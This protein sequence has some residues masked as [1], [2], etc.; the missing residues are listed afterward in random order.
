MNTRPQ[1]PS[2][3]EGRNRL[4]T[5]GLE[6]SS[7]PLLP[8]TDLPRDPRGK[9]AGMRSSRQLSVLSLFLHLTLVAIHIALLV[10]WFRKW[11]HRLVF[12]IENENFV[13][14]L[15]KG[16]S[17]TFVT[18]YSALL[19]FVTQTLSF[20][21]DFRR[22]QML[23]AT[24]DNIIAWT[25]LG[26]AVLRLWQQRAIPASIFGVLSALIYLACLLLLHT[27][28]P[29]MLAPKSFI[30][31][32]SLA[33]STQS[34]PAFN[35]SGYD[36]ADGN[37]RQN[38]MRSAQQYAGGSLSFFPFLTPENTLGLY[39]ATLYDVLDSNMGAGSV[40]VNATSFNIS[41]GYIPDMNVT[42]GTGLGPYL[43]LGGTEYFLAL[44]D[45]GVIAPLY[46]SVN[47][48]TND[49]TVPIPFPSPSIFYTSIPVLD[50]NH[51][52]SPWV[53]LTDS[54]GAQAI[55]L[56]RCSL[57]LV[58]QTAV[59]DSQSHKLTFLETTIN[60]T[61]STWLPFSGPSDNL[62]SIAFENAQGFLNI[63]ES[64]YT[65][66]PE[67][68][69]P[70][71]VS[72][73]STF[74]GLSVADM[75]LIQ[76][77][78]LFPFNTTSRNYVYLHE[79]EKELA[80]I[81]ASMF[82]TLGHVPPLSG[83]SSL[84]S[85]ATPPPVLNVALLGGQATAE[86]LIVQDRLDLNIISI[87][88]G[89]LASIIL[90]Y[91]SARFLC[92][93]K[94]QAGCTA[95]EVDGVDIL[96]TIWLY[97][98]HSELVVSLKQVEY[99]TDLNLRK[100]GMVPIQ[101]IPTTLA[102]RKD[103]EELGAKSE[104]TDKPT[105]RH[106]E[107]VSEEVP[108]RSTWN[109]DRNLSLI[110]VILHS[111]LLVI[112]LVLV[113][114]S[115]MEIEHRVIFSLDNQPFL[116]WLIT[117]IAT[118]FIT[119]YSAALIF[120]TQTLSLK[121]FLR[122]TQMLA[123]T[124]DTIAAWRGI[125]SA[126]VS[127]LNQRPFTDSIFGVGSVFL[128]L[129]SILVLHNT[130]PV[131]LSVQTFDS[132]SSLPV[133]TQSLPNFTFSNY[134]PSSLDARLNVLHSP[135]L[136]AQG[137]LFFLPFLNSSAPTLG[138]HAGSLYDVLEYNAGTGN[139]TVEATGMNMNCG[140]LADPVVNSSVG[141]INILGTDYGLGYTELGIISTL[142]QHI[143]FQENV[144]VPPFL[145]SALFYSTVPIFD[146]NGDVGP[147]VNITGI[148]DGVGVSNIQIFRCSL[149]P[150]KQ[151]AIIDAQS[152]VL[153][154]DVINK[155]SSAWK[156]FQGTSENSTDADSSPYNTLEDY[157]ESWY[158]AMPFSNIPR[159]Y[160]A[161]LDITVSEMFLI[162]ELNLALFNSS[163]FT[164]ITLHQ[165]ESALSELVASM[166]W[167]MGHIPPLPG[168]VPTSS[169]GIGPPP[170]KVSLIQGTA[171][172]TQSVFKARLDSSTSEIIVGGVASAILLLLSLQF[173][174]LR[175][176]T[177]REDD[178][179]TGMG[180]LHT[181]WLYRNHPQLETTLEQVIHPTDVNLRKAGMVQTRLAG[182]ASR[183]QDIRGG[184]EGS[185]TYHGLR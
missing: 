47:T 150:I 145:G 79:V 174:V 42:L 104:D 157:W 173:V 56:F 127:V 60:K 169:D 43:S 3:S 130:S 154:I 85:T 40:S 131:L 112:H 148:T 80:N 48:D 36:L 76:R 100:A 95:A 71:S 167:T 33:V 5:F 97:R 4:S 94:P 50:S 180:M 118:I 30:V 175:E 90:L 10:V 164:N 92:F 15:V 120:L 37:N 133:T 34:L 32:R 171:E 139:T 41:C 181:I 72:D 87:M 146:T 101:L 66:M 110:S 35:F 172:V 82:W 65:A 147:L 168:Y 6:G 179:I 74:V 115:G 140:Y 69:A 91:L 125:G 141:S 176:K 116:S 119:I 126:L 64:W 137:S 8:A 96:Q 7:E 88:E 158:S 39:E 14:R 58:E 1:P 75:A 184:D 28:F 183:K 63:W 123:A 12:G 89:L 185:D 13:F 77:L 61:T 178:V 62:S 20:R 70:P 108:N 136:Y 38:I 54:L 152:H 2:L 49:D 51:N 132:E 138:L 73:N 163:G 53:N 170:V 78:Q 102:V 159:S 52:T 111:T 124:H 31:K 106:S 22:R 55:Q 114:L 151:S 45:S 122:Q 59:V 155:T 24:H 177:E 83:Y 27:T 105:M 26:S 23:T 113:V 16:I 86:E 29:A 68:Q 44:T 99:P 9:S 25:G 117:N 142:S 11:E 182:D 128:Y 149:E 129:A 81:V 156:P 160:G 144:T 46:Y 17:T 166:Y 162:E 19:V 67:A 143:P 109:S 84:N 121:R 165:F 18:L 21:R 135:L 57:A 153:A 98:D 93:E 103:F 161:D 134:N 107:N